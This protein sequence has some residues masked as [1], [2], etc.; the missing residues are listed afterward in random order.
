VL[1]RE[2]AFQ[3]IRYLGDA[4]PVLP[5][6]M[7]KQLVVTGNEKWTLVLG[8]SIRSKAE[9]VALVWCLVINFQE[10][11]YAL[12]IDLKVEVW[13]AGRL[14]LECREFPEVRGTSDSSQVYLGTMRREHLAVQS[15]QLGDQVCF[16]LKS[17]KVDCTVVEGVVCVVYSEDENLALMVD[18]EVLSRSKSQDL[19]LQFGQLVLEDKDEPTGFRALLSRS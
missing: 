10:S 3:V 8:A 16:H 11:V 2:P 12:W 6:G 17:Q 14:V 5:N 9:C 15:I 4:V 19:A 1:Q 13:R 18:S 7:A